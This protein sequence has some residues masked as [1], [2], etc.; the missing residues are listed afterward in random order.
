MAATHCQVCHRPL[1]VQKQSGLVAGRTTTTLVTCE[2]PTCPL[3]GV[4]IDTRDWPLAAVEVAGYERAAQDRKR[5]GRAWQ[6]STRPTAR[7]ATPRS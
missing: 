5:R 4:T 3:R 1:D 6:K 2:T 7:F